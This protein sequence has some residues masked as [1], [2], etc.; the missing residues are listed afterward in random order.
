MSRQGK[1]SRSDSGGLTDKERTELNTDLERFEKIVLFHKKNRG[2][3]VDERGQRSG[4]R[5]MPQVKDGKC[6]FI[7]KSFSVYSHFFGGGSLLSASYR[8][9]SSAS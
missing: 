6:G 8:E 1:Y 5:R 2:Q 7:S 9:K 4:G 3:I